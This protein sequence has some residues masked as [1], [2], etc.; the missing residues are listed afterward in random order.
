MR[1]NVM[2][3]GICPVLGTL[4]PI[5]GADVTE[6]T[7]VK[8]INTRSLR[9]FDTLTG[10][11]ITTRNYK[12]IITKREVA[13][14]AQPAATA[15]VPTEPVKVSPNPKTAKKKSKKEPVDEAPAIVEAVTEAAPEEIAS[16]PVE[17]PTTTPVAV[18]EEQ[19]ELQPEPTESEPTVETPI[20]TV[21]ETPESSTETESEETEKTTTFT[22]KKKKRR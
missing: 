1:V 5:I 21:D 10:V 17:V 14:V 12:N 16:E 13:P 7:L 15:V 3:K 18:E 22:S 6:G 20:E 4:L 19:S 2:G 8:L 11:Q 9:V